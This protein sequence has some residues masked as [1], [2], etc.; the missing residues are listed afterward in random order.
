METK[1]RVRDGVAAL[2]SGPAYLTPAECI[3]MKTVGV[4]VVGMS[5]AHENVVAKHNGMKVTRSTRGRLLFL[6]TSK[7]VGLCYRAEGQ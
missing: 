6:L 5:G 1:P 3:L 7:I 4:D 2:V